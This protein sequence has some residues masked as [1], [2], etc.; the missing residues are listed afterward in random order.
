MDITDLLAFQ[1]DKPSLKRSRDDR[2]QEEVVEPP[3]MK[4]NKS[5]GG[6][7]GREE[8][9]D[10]TLIPSGISEEERERIMKMMEEEPEVP[11]L[12]DTSLRKLILSFEKKV[13]RNQELRIKFPDL[14]EKFMESEIELNDVIQELHV[15]ATVPDM[16]HHLKE[17]NATKSLLQLIGHENTD[18]SIAVINLLQE[19][20]DVDTLTESEDGATVF[21][22]ALLEEQVCATLVQNLD[23]LDD[24]V[25]EEAEGIH[26][27]LG[28]IEN[29]AE[30]R[31]EM[32]ADAAQ[33]GLMQWL[34]RKLKPKVPFDANKLYCSEILA[35]L[36]Q[37]TERNRILL[38]E[39]DG[40]DALLQQLAY[41]KKHDPTNSEELEMMEN[42]FNCLCSSLMLPANKM[43]FLRG[44]GLQLMNLMLREKKQ[45]RHSALKVLNHAMTGAEAGDNCTKFIDILGL[46]SL[47]P[48][49]M[50]TPKRVKRGPGDSEH[51]EHVCSI[52]A[53]LF[54]NVSGSHLQRLVGKFT[55][56]DHAKVDRLMELHFT[57]LGRVQACDDKIEREKQRRLREGD[58][59]DDD[60]E[61]EYY[62]Q[63][64]D[65]GLF[66]LQLIDYTMLELCCNS[67][68][69]SIKNRVLQLLNMRGGTIT[70]IRHVVRE[71]AGNIGDADSEERGEAEKQRLL[72]L[73]NRF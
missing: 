47:F 69:S 67:G 2:L 17:L 14:P 43:A 51:E 37:D 26:N 27:T 6:R 53:A 4:R 35:I 30:F 29:M 5:G 31:P 57:Y 65:A 21:I 16:Y 63:R 50:K 39:L 25:K 28:I 1:P 64:L 7:G 66:S 11:S 73:I 72:T 56:S 68:V 42:L 61:D 48:L 70:D 52:I 38:G 12:D 33:Q 49:F 22:D 40:I 36:L 46:R 3:Q 60:Q 58:I 20:T 9:E 19:M 45:S 34:L 13:Y 18:I 8:E 44:E 23:R 24:T 71:Y 32:C 15:I 59:I 62:I 55:E 54:R 10:E 41:F